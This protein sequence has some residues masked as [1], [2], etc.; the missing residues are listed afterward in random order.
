MQLSRFL[1]L[2]PALLASAQITQIVDGITSVVS[3]ITSV[4]GE[5]TGG[6]GSLFTVVTSDAGSVYTVRSR[7]SQS[8][9]TWINIIR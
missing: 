5:I 3:D 7:A 8:Q 9:L 4:G 6:A 1:L 2:T